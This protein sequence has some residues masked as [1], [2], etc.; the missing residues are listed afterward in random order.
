MKKTFAVIGLG[1]YGRKVCEVLAEKG[2]EVIAIDNSVEQMNKVKDFV[3]QA[4]LLDATDADSISEAPFDQVDAAIIA[5]GDNI[6]ASILATTLLKQLG[7]PYI[8][9]RAVNKTHFQVLKQVG[10]DEVINIE[11]DEGKRVALNLISPSVMER[12]QLSKDIILSEMLLPPAYNKKKVSDLDF[13]GKFQI[14]L[15]GIQRSMKSLDSDGMSIKKEI[16]ILNK[17]EYEMLDGDVL[18]LVGEEA[19]IE[20]FQKSGEL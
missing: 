17:P 20:I 15:V 13:T 5:I 19:K 12:V 9:A 8:I 4:I 3:S 11:E 1:L 14:S 6:E 7:V 10:A 2:G 16:L 18:I